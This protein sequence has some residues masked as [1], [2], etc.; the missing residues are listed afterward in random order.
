MLSNRLIRIAC[1]CLFPLFCSSPVWTAEI[2]GYVRD[3]KTGEGVARAI[4]RAVPVERNRRDIQTTTNRAGR[5]N[6]DVIRGSY[7]IFVS[8]P[9][10]NYLPGY[11]DPSGRGI[12]EVIDIPTFDSFKIVD[13]TL[14]AGGSISG[15]VTRLADG[16][17][18]PNLRIQA[19]SAG[20]QFVATSDPAGHYL[21]RALPAGTYRIHVVPLDENFVPVFYDDA[22]T[23]E[24]AITLQV[25]PRQ[26]ISGINFRLRTGSRIV[27]RAYARKNREPIIG[28]RVLAQRLNSMEAPLYSFTDSEGFYEIRG[29]TPGTYLVE[30]GSWG[31][32]GSVTALKRRYLVQYHENRFDRELAEPIEIEAGATLTGVN[33]S[34]VEGGGISGRVVTRIDSHPLAE[35]SL[36]PEH[37]G[38][39]IASPPQGHSDA[40]GRYLIQ[41]LPPGEYR[42]DTS[43]PD[44]IRKYVS[45]FYRDKL[46]AERADR[47][48]V[49]EN[50]I[51]QR[52]D[53][54]L[55]LGA[56]LKGKLH[57]EDDF[58][59]NP[60][61]DGILITPLGAAVEDYGQREFKVKPDG[62]FVIEGLP[63]GRYSISP[64]VSD[65][66]LT[67][68]PRK[69]SRVMELVEGE[70][71]QDV[72]FTFKLAGSISGRIES[73]SQYYT[74]DK[75]LLLLI[76]VKENTR[77]YF[78]VSE[79]QF[80][81]P[82][83]EPGKYVV[84]LVSNPDK[85]HPDGNYKPA[86]VFETRLV[87]VSKG[88]ST[89]DLNLT[90]PMEA[91]IY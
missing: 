72:D 2:V 73:A 11:Y 65:P 88:K 34:L 10:S 61:S 62:S 33:F 5:Y 32:P 75:L 38:K 17:P 28:M 47:I 22:L 54:S 12:G 60:A 81:I 78:D 85:T 67:P 9:D 89:R 64:K 58:K 1:G 50:A 87:E 48:T 4:V 71:V 68:D 14:E 83:V 18:I 90:I 84:V 36:I 91:A 37:L 86:Q 40:E 15:E 3:S 35:V 6:L 66:N 23:L 59:F 45:V 16:R 7:R 41:N 80:T 19:E 29:L 31:S 70:V 56:V 25:E 20:A 52:I 24:R 57:G 74:L 27:G 77:T 42:L 82:A 43:L 79:Q 21:L 63:S 49:E 76:N 53:F 69:L 39:E 51:A 44:P 55:A 30:S 26:E 46:S 8:V 13:V